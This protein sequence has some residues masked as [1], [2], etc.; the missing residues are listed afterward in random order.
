MNVA[1]CIHGLG[2]GGAQQVIKEIVAGTDPGAFRHVVLSPEDGVLRG[3]IERAGARIR[4]IP[5]RLRKLDPFWVPSLAAALRDERIDVVHTHLFGDSLHGYLAARLAGGL[6]VV[7]TLHCAIEFLTPLQQRGYR[8]LRHRGVRMVACS[9]YVRRSFAS[10]W[11]PAGTAIQT[12]ANGISTRGAV[13]T[14]SEAARAS[15]G[16]ASGVPVIGCVGRLEVEKAFD[17]LISAFARVQSRDVQLVLVGD[18][19]LR[20]A[21]EAHALREGVGCRVHFTGFQPDVATLLPAFDVFAMSSPS[22]GLPIALLEAMAVGRCI[23][24]AGSPGVRDVLTD[25]CDGL[26]VTPGDQMALASALSRAL[27]DAGLRQRLGRRANERFRGA[28]GARGMVAA[29]EEAYRQLH[30]GRPRPR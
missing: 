23:V 21:L 11:G 16:L 12:I 3:E 1:H 6:P 28:F 22:E 8:W 27:A 30:A 2:L 17:L 10:A 13:A 9:E 24:A 26:V 29:Y 5:R 25:E 20:A 14:T 19:T 18:G 4:I 15:L 7:M